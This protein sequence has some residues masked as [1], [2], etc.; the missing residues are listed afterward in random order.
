MRYI[1]KTKRQKTKLKRQKTKKFLQK[2]GLLLNDITNSVLDK[3]YE[4]VNYLRI[5]KE[6][7][8][9]IVSGEITI[10]NYKLTDF[11][12]IE[13]DEESDK[14][15]YKNLIENYLIYIKKIVIILKNTV[16][17]ISN[18]RDIN[19]IRGTQIFYDNQLN[20]ISDEEKI[21]SL[22]TL[23]LKYDDKQDSETIE[24]IEQKIGK[25]TKYKLSN[26]ELLDLF[27]VEKN[28][29]NLKGYVPFIVPKKNISFSSS[30]QV[31]ST[32]SN[33]NIEFDTLQNCVPGPNVVFP[34]KGRILA[35]LKNYGIKGKFNCGRDK[36]PKYENG[37]YCCVSQEPTDQ[38]LLD[39]I[40]NIIEKAMEV[41]SGV[42]FKNTKKQTQTFIIYIIK[43]RNELLKN[44]HLV[45][46]LELSS[47]KD[48]NQ[49]K[50]I[51]E[52]TQSMDE[53]VSQL[54]GDKRFD[55]EE[56]DSDFLNKNPYYIKDSNT[57]L[58]RLEHS[59]NILKNKNMK[60]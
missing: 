57:R 43:L 52:W 37:K 9:K 30:M 32:N 11:D 36:Y 44:P 60:K 53:E 39:Y 40:N 38:D 42:I 28:T 1:K 20:G 54:S 18:M 47:D 17:V 16:E 10:H 13:S 15:S 5:T 7:F 59:E 35:Y 25:P 21:S 27:K 55:L 45:D 49:Y 41:Q 56:I 33:S 23:L 2:G 3:I 51:E 34:K 12:I 22:T 26:G 8:Y 19:K 29:S 50:S 58:R 48:G 24:G 14:E 31:H 6:F 4:S 46:N